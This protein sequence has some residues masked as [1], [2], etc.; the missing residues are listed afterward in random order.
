MEKKQ[1]KIAVA[2]RKCAVRGTTGTTHP[3]NLH[4]L[5][6]THSQSN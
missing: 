1:K 3:Q 5:V 4:I 6:C 2:T